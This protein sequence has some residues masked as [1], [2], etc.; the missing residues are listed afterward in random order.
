MMYRRIG[1]SA[2]RRVGVSACRRWLPGFAT[3]F[4]YPTIGVIN[5]VYDLRLHLLVRIVK[6]LELLLVDVSVPKRNF[7]VDL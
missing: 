2:Y 7:D 3:G 4:Y 5:H 1:V 6:L